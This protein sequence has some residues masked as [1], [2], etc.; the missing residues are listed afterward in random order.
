MTHSCSWSLAEAAAAAGVPVETLL[1]ELT[2]VVAVR[3]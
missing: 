3:A 1:R 2:D